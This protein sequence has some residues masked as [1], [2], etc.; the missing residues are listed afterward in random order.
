VRVSMSTTESNSKG[1]D[2]RGITKVSTESRNPPP[3]SYARPT[4]PPPPPP[5]KDGK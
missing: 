1:T 5:K 2:N 4:P 3:K